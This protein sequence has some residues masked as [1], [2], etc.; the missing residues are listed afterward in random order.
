[1]FKWSADYEGAAFEYKKAAEAFRATKNYQMFRTLLQTANQNL[2]LLAEQEKGSRRE[3]ILMYQVAKNYEDLAKS[4]Q[5]N[6]SNSEDMDSVKDYVRFIEKSG[7]IYRKHSSD[8]AIHVYKSAGSTL[9]SV[10]SQRACDINPNIG[11]IEELSLSTAKMLAAAAEISTGDVSRGFETAK[12][13]SDC[14]KLHLR[15]YNLTHDEKQLQKVTTYQR[16]RNHVQAAACVEDE[17]DPQKFGNFATEM[18]MVALANDDFVAARRAFN[19]MTSGSQ[20][21]SEVTGFLSIDET[22]VAAGAVVSSADYHPVKR[23]LCAWEDDNGPVVKNILKNDYVL[24]NME[25]E[26]CRLVAAMTNLPTGSGNLVP[27]QPTSGFSAAP[28][29]NMEPLEDEESESEDLC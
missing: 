23:L 9:Q 6:A 5:P 1:M 15:L 21:N 28:G 2:V 29:T 20:V 10:I 27:D 14:A 24:K 25:P 13:Y 26:Y 4:V 17:S 19:C 11:F 18:V 7:A 16:L 12:L 8:T 22:K 3:G